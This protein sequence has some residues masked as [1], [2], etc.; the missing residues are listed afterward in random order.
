MYRDGQSFSDSLLVF[1]HIESLLSWLH[2]FRC[3][4]IIIS[5]YLSRLFRDFSPLNLWSRFVSLGR[6]PIL[7]L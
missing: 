5:Y 2:S 4:F 1:G 3:V 6:F 7:I